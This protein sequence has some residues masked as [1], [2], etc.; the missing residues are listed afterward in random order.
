MK[1]IFMAALLSVFVAMPAV[2]ADMYVGINVGSAKI[3]MPGFDNTTSFALLGGYSFN[4]YFAAELAYSDFGS[5][6]YSGINVK[7]SAW[8]ISGVLSYPFNEQ[9]SVF[10]KLGF[11]STTLDG[12]GFPSE[13]DSDMT[14]GLGGQF[15]I[16]KQ[17]GIRLGYDVYK[18]G[19]GVT[20]DE[21]VPSIGGVFKF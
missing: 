4:E 11:A 13:T 10:G 3:D 8:S 6:D 21:K 16:N 20:A 2:A 1:R 5:K 18:V 14:Y 17:F 15:N 12:T 19:S 7:S 9:F